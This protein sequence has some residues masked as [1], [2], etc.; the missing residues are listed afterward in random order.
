MAVELSQVAIQQ[1]TSVNDASASEPIEHKAPSNTVI[2]CTRLDYVF[3]S[4]LCSIGSDADASL[5]L[6]GSCAF[7][8]KLVRIRTGHTSFLFFLEINYFIC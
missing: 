4:A 2:A 5:T 8:Q 7:R 6:V 1:P 3:A